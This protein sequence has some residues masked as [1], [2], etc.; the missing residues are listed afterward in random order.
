MIG[1]SGATAVVAVDGIAV[2]RMAQPEANVEEM[3][4]L[5]DRIKESPGPRVIAIVT[6][7]SL[8][9]GMLLLALGLW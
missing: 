1:L 5:L 4:A 7:V 3:A 8:L 9:L 6:G 2:S